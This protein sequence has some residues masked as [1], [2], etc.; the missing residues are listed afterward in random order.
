MN[1]MSGVSAGV[2]ARFALKFPAFALALV[3]LF[4]ASSA[5]AQSPTAPARPEVKQDFCPGLVAQD[6]PRVMPASLHLAALT[7]DQ[8]RL[9]FIGHSTFL[10]ESPQLVRIATDYN[11][12]VRPPMLPDI[13]TMNRAHSTHYTERPEPGIKHVLRGWREDGAPV[14]HDVTYKDV[15]V[16]SI[17]TNIRDWSG[18]T[19]R[20]GN[21]IF[22]FEV[23]SLCVAHLGHLHHTLNQ[24]QLNEIG[25]VDVVLVPVDG[26]YTLDLDGMVE[27]LQSL[28]APLMIPMHYFS[29][30]TLN[31]FLERVREQYDVENADTPSIVVSRATLP[32]KPK[33][34]VLPGR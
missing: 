19:M 25:R 28:K 2:V 15:H 26:S 33:F 5:P 16:R 32:T 27:V 17:A 10:I 11:D 12:Y 14:G 9:T 7:A 8:V 23:G 1:G 31:R 6:T 21:S 34:L 29:S 18:G 22:V 4:A 13:V 3:G 24:Q 20:H 30:G